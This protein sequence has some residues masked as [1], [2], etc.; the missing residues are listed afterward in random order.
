[1][2][3]EGAEDWCWK[4]DGSEEGGVW[5]MGL[6]R[7]GGRGLGR[8]GLRW[9]RQRGGRRVSGSAGRDAGWDDES[10]KRREPVGVARKDSDALGS[11]AGSPTKEGFPRGGGGGGN[12]FREELGRQQ[13]SRDFRAELEKRRY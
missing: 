1:M 2:E 5:G 11:L 9:R 6:G 3:S 10:W 13:E 4:C 12:V 7:V 8:V